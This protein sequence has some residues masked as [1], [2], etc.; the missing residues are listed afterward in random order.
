MR[1][2]RFCPSMGGEVPVAGTTS[3]SLII[4]LA[5]SLQSCPSQPRESG[6]RG[7]LRVVVRGNGSAG[8]RKRR[9]RRRMMRKRG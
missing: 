5:I 3:S 8:L 2:I 4:F 1:K 6:S 7:S 9:R